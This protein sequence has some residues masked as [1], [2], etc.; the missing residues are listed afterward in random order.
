MTHSFYLVMHL[1]GVFLIL[2]GLSGFTIRTL[3]SPSDADSRSWKR[4]TA[5]THG[6][7]MLLALVGG[8]GMLARL[9]INWPWPSWVLVK[10]C[11]WILLGLSMSAA[12]RKRIAKFWWWIAPLLAMI[13]L[14]SAVYK[15]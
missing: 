1:S 14:I 8:F 7:G 11:I 4:A 15:Y 13:A 10:F 3:V 6:V 5:I 9:Q 2:T 12:K